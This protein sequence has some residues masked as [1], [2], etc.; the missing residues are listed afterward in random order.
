MKLNARSLV[1][2][3][4]DTSTSSWIVGTNALREENEVLLVISCTKSKYSRTALRLERFA[5]ASAGV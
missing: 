2:L 3:V 4:G 5:V 1:P